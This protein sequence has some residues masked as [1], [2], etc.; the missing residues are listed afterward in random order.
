MCKEIKW[1]KGQ[2]QYIPLKNWP[3]VDIKKQDVAFFSTN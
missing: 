3:L 2:I 1:K